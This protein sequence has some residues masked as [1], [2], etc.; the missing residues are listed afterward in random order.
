MTSEQLLNILKAEGVRP[1]KVEQIMKKVKNIEEHNET[2]PNK[3]D[4]VSLSEY[5]ICKPTIAALEVVNVRNVG[6]LKKFV[7]L[8]GAY[9]LKDK[10][11][12]I[13]D[14]RYDELKRIF[15]WLTDYEL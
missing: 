11:R 3:E 7:I 10:I 6:D 14:S 5:P 13:G 4:I 15:P 1:L 8:N 2:S 9:A 12:A